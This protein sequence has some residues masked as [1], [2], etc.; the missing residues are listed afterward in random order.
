MKFTFFR[1]ILF[2][3]ILGIFS[4]CL[5][6]GDTTTVSSSPYFSS[7]VFESND[8]IPYL[9]TAA[10]T[11]SEYDTTLKDSI[12][13]NLDS[14]PY[15][16]RIDSVY[17]TF[18]FDSSAG[19]RLYYQ[20]GNKYNRDS[21]WL[22]GTDTIDFRQTVRVRNYATDGKTYRDYIVKTNV[23]QVDPE[24]YQWG[25]ASDNLNQSG[26][27]SQKAVTRND[28]LFYYQND[29]TNGFLNIS[30]NG[31]RWTPKSVTGLPVNTPLND[32]TL[33]KGQMFISKDGFNL[34]SS[35]NG[36]N[37][38]KKSLSS[39]SFKSLLFV[40]N[41][42]LW[43]VVQAADASYHF[44]N[45]TDG[46]IWTMK[47]TIPNNFPISDFAAVT[48]KSPT[49]K[50]RVLVTNGYSSNGVV[51]YNRWTTEDTNG[52]NWL[53]FNTE[54]NSLED[55]V[56]GGSI[57]SYDS[58]LLA[59]GLKSDGTSLYKISKDEG[60]S[61][62]TPD[63]ALN[64][65]PSAYLDNPRHYQSVVIFKAKTYDKIN[66]SSLKEEIINSNRIFI[67]GGKLNSTIYSD[68]WTGKI[69]WENFLRQ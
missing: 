37:W 69:N 56:V 68:V 16:T 47:G 51:E 8:S 67:I 4:S 57:I 55:L 20:P 29:G 48:F 54:N 34:Y 21:V 27:V 2:S 59:F 62:Q 44:A 23:H 50:E 39:F 10:F 31:Y 46:A 14:L 3:F 28:T 45:S 9:S 1:L 22:T 65:L 49:G 35:S 25:K 19:I 15:G 36:I 63:T 38:T 24:V 52:V 13:V 12:I 5:G 18:S 7:L 42:Q 60:L 58:K 40:F 32:I 17:P 53:D 26:L 61:W 64:I 11:L 30:T 66:S 41:D 33:F 6:S 43:A